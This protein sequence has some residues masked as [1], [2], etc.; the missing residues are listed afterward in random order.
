MRMSTKA[1]VTRV[2]VSSIMSSDLSPKEIRDLCDAL[3]G[4]G[5]YTHELGYHLR[6]LVE[7]TMQQ[8][9]SVSRSTREQDSDDIIDAIYL[10]VKK[11]KI[12]REHFI[13]MLCYS[14]NAIGDY[15]DEKKFSIRRMIEIFVDNSKSSCVNTLFEILESPDD[16]YF[17]HIL[18]EG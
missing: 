14:D 1:R 13:R 5:D 2:L 17:E 9:E 12:R 16:E 11:K 6:A 18:D 3:M 4:K 8:S 7:T 15:F 10:L